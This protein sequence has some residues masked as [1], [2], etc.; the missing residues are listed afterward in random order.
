MSFLPPKQ[1]KINSDYIESEEYAQ[2]FQGI[3]GNTKTD[4]TLA[5]SAQKILSHR[6]GTNFEDLYLIDADTGDV[7]HSLTT[8]NVRNGIKYDAKTETAIANATKSGKRIIAMHNHPNNYPPSFDDGV[9]AKSRGYVQ[10]VVVG[11]DGSIYTYT[12]TDEIYKESDCDALHEM[13]NQEIWQRMELKNTWFTSLKVFGMIV[14]ER[15]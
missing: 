4:A 9:S 7:I 6:S 10:G 5:D 14:S 1:N 3:T 2:R 15:K 11:H 8:S 12:P 13:I